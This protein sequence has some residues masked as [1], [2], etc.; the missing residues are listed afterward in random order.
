MF[1]SIANYLIKRAKR[2]PYRHLP[3]YMRRWWLVPYEKAGSSYAEGTGPVSW[4]RPIAKLLQLCGIAVRVHEILSSDV[5]R[6]MHDHPWPYV[7]VILKGGYWEVTPESTRPSIDDQGALFED[8][9][10]VRQKW[11]G[12]GSVLVRRS[13]DRHY[14]TL[15]FDWDRHEDTPATTLFITG[16]LVQTWGFYPDGEAKVPFDEYLKEKQ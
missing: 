16:P 5:D 12:P 1:D 8:G 11:Y 14:L 13:T 10:W 7:T 4:R 2:T 9:R 3:G 15:D 6:A